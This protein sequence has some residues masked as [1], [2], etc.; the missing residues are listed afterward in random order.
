MKAIRSILV[1]PLLIVCLAGSH[2]VSAEDG[3]ST[4]VQGKGTA[5]SLKPV[6]EMAG[7][8]SLHEDARKSVLRL[9]RAAQDGDLRGLDAAIGAGDAVNERDQYGKTALMYGVMRGFVLV[10]ERLLEAGA[11][12][13][14]RAPNGATALFMAAVRGESSIIEL[15][16]KANADIMVKGPKGQ[17][18]MEAARAAYSNEGGAKRENPAVLALLAGKTLAAV[19]EAR[20]KRF[21]RKWSTGKIF[22][23]HERGPSMIVIRDTS[24][25]GVSR[26][27]VS[28]HKITVSQYQECVKDG[29][30][31][32]LP[33]TFSMAVGLGLKAIGKEPPDDG[34]SRVVDL[35]WAAEQ[36]Y[37]RWLSEKTGL[38]YRGM[39]ER[40][41]RG[42]HPESLNK[43]NWKEMS[44]TVN[45]KDLIKA[46][47]QGKLWYGDDLP[48]LY[49]GKVRTQFT[50]LFADEL[51]AYLRQMHAYAEIV[52]ERLEGFRVSRE[53]VP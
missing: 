14:I 18:A 15:L 5:E 17:T 19:R 2:T 25:D 23:D 45:M 7:Q 35:P 32:P 44:H 6:T 16:M 9:H 51:K 1:M 31:K 26:L 38:M 8:N 37:V 22:K 36:Q 47:P 4:S 39:T 48:G 10:V 50:P 11:D 53:L 40:E 30:C 28:Q 49:K 29:A 33:S 52:L 46:L 21:Q 12:P 27:A 3:A 42:R 34:G 43:W 24:P 13:N 20:L 41:Y